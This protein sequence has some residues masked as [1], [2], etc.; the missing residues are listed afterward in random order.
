M[1]RRGVANS[2]YQAAM[3]VSWAVTTPLGGLLIA[4]V[5]IHRYL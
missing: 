1:Q 4:H 2:S 5:A 3:Q